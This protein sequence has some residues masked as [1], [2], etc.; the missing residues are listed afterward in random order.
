MNI[1]ISEQEREDLRQV[2]YEKVKAL[3]EEIERQKRLANRLNLI[4]ERLANIK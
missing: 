2:L 3:D 4:L 1:K